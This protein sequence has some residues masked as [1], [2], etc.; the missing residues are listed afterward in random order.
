M[1]Q[2]YSTQDKFVEDIGT[3]VENKILILS[4][5]EIDQIIYDTYKSINNSEQDNELYI[6]EK[7]QNRFASKIA[8]YRTRQYKQRNWNAFKYGII[9]LISV[10]ILV[11]LLYIVMVY[12]TNERER[13]AKVIQELT[14]YGINVT[15]YSEKHW[16]IKNYYLQVSANE[17][18][19]F[20]QLLVQDLINQAFQL[21]ANIHGWLRWTI[22]IFL[23]GY[24][25]I[26][27]KIIRR[28]VYNWLWPN[29]KQYYKQWCL[30]EQEIEERISFLKIKD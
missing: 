19:L 29:Y 3:I 13:L 2:I 14:E 8:Y 21:H 18:V 26:S 28:I 4:K 30:V 10:I 7:L 17:N 22:M 6:L 23:F 9:M 24:P 1:K 12:D 20:D 16:K 27:V 25:L 5:E 15:Q 11:Y